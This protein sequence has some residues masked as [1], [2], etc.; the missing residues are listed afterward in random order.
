MK[1]VYIDAESFKNPQFVSQAIRVYTARN[2]QIHFLVKGKKE[3]F[4]SISDLD[5]L[6][7]KENISESD[8]SNYKFRLI[9]NDDPLTNFDGSSNI[10]LFVNKNKTIKYLL[11]T[12]S[13]NIDEKHLNNLIIDAKNLFYCTTKKDGEPSICFAKGF[14]TSKD[15]IKLFK[16]HPNYQGEISLKD[17]FT[18]SF[19]IIFID[20]SAA[21]YLFNL[22]DSFAELNK[23]EEPKK[24]EKMSAS[25]FSKKLFTFTRVKDEIDYD[26]LLLYYFVEQSGDY[27]TFHIKRLANLT[28]LFKILYD[29]DEL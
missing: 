22:I 2:N 14:N 24:K 10:F 8:L 5:C 13:E 28:A 15:L 21:Y 9:A 3:D 12:V 18:N 20:N 17:L 6:T 25:F 4:V 29:I 16:K 7:V 19:D 26:A 23:N 1:N 27:Y 11:A